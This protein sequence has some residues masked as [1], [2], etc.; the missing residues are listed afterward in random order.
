L[1]AT[2]TTAHAA[3]KLLNYA[4]THSDA[5]ILYH[6]SNMVLYLHSNASYLLASKACS[7]AGGHFF[8]SDN[9]PDPKQAPSQQPSHNGPVHT[10]CQIMRKVLASAAKAKIGALF[11]NGQE[12]LPIP[13]TLH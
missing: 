7:R 11:L 10:T 12:A 2:A 13:I 9:P 4:A 3:A 8:L 1:I 6:A 5:T